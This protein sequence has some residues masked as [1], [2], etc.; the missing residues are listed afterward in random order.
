MA[1]DSSVLSDSLETLLELF[2]TDLRDLKF[3]DVDAERLSEAAGAVFAA[4]E[5]VSAA[6]AVL[7]SA[8]AE[9]QRN[10]EALLQKGQRALAYARVWAEEQPELLEKL[11]LIHLPR[12]GR[13]GQA[14]SRG[15]VGDAA[16]PKRRG[17]PPKSRRE[18]APNL[19]A[20][21]SAD[22]GIPEEQS[23]PA[24]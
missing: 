11:A 19:F 9:L 24:V 6:E 18:G 16:P 7:D 15:P 17:R 5:D 8:R 20:L 3:P 4:A 13:R 12:P 22:A 21:E 10:Q 2:K 23:A 14:E 1:S